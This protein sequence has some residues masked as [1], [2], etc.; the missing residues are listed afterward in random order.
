MYVDKLGM[1]F[2]VDG[3]EVEGQINYE[4]IEGQEC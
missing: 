3:D 1:D 2:N 4:R